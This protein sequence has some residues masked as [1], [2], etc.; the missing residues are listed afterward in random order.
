MSASERAR[1]RYRRG[2]GTNI[3]LI[4]FRCETGCGK[5]SKKKWRERKK[6]FASREQAREREREREDLT[7]EPIE[8]RLKYKMVLRIRRFYVPFQLLSHS[9]AAFFSPLSPSLSHSR[10]RRAARSR[11]ISRARFS[12]IFLH[13]VPF[14]DRK[15]RNIILVFGRATNRCSR[16]CPNKIY[17]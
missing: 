14:V 17:T 9:I 16:F 4:D 12:I 11:T 15:K 10:V 5:L 1:E 3:F 6:T 2:K 13:F 7:G 8:V